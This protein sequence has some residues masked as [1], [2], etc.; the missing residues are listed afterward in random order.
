MCTRL[1]NDAREIKKLSQ[2][3]VSTLTSDLKFSVSQ[4]KR[5]FCWSSPHPGFL[6]W[7]LRRTICILK[8]RGFLS[9]DSLTD[10]GL[11]FSVAVASVLGSGADWPFEA[12]KTSASHRFPYW[13]SNA[14]I[15]RNMSRLRFAIFSCSDYSA[16]L[17]LAWAKSYHWEY[18]MGPS[19]NCLLQWKSN[20]FSEYR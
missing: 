13:I 9:D 1:H 7:H 12:K 20:H 3:L 17:N 2:I 14:K 10:F 16:T 5:W 19:W 15:T 8:L 18:R 6:D 11:Y 4:K